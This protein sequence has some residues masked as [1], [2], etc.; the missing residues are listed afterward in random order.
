M[1]PAA[2]VAFSLLLF[3]RAADGQVRPPNILL[4]V[5]NDMGYADIG[6]HGHRTAIFGR[7]HLGSADRFHPMARGFEE[8]FGFLGGDHSTSTLNTGDPIPSSRAGNPWRRRR[9]LVEAWRRWSTEL[10]KPLWAPERPRGDGRQRQ[11]VGQ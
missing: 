11:E 10:V 1:L 4:I 2:A 6:V 5:A 7:W 3:S 8:L 9:T